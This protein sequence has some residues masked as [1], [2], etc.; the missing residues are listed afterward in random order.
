VAVR[1]AEADHQ[2]R[3]RLSAADRQAAERLALVG[4][5]VE[6]RLAEADRLFGEWRA[7][8]RSGFSA[9]VAEVAEASQ[10]MT[11]ASQSTTWPEPNLLPRRLEI[12]PPV[13][14]RSVDLRP[15]P[16]PGPGE[17]D[18]SSPAELQEVRVEGHAL[19]DAVRRTL[20]DGNVQIELDDA[21]AAVG[22]S[23]DRLLAMLEE[24]LRAGDVPPPP[25]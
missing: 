3:E 8:W 2:V 18:V 11:E 9:R 17:V 23:H 12:V 22:E 10:S 13:D 19:A 6:E 15:D 14:E 25:A 5:Q 1:L 24:Q 20:R 16:P 7:A 21:L 4:R